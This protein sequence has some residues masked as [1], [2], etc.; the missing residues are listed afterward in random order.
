M[1]ERF[2]KIFAANLDKLLIGK[3]LGAE[4]LGYY[5]IAHTLIIIP[6]FTINPLVTKV[7]FPVFSIIQDNMEKMNSYF[8]KAINLLVTLNFPIYFGMMITAPDF[9]PLIFGEKWTASVAVI[10]ILSLEA[11][12]WTIS[13]PVGSVLL[14]KG[15]ADL[16]FKLNV[17]RS[18]CLALSVLTAYALYPSI[19]S[20]AIGIVTSRYLVDPFIHRFMA[21]NYGV[22]YG[23]ILKNILTISAVSLGMVLTVCLVETLGIE[24]DYVDLALKVLLGGMTYALLLALF[25]KESK[26]LL[27]SLRR[28]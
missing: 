27:L 7:S 13:N 20:V 14:A 17:V 8:S 16:S 28:S 5:T 26:D 9:V 22:N 1:G 3:F 2:L 23:R 10:Q 6:L 25:S 19:E 11:L 12:L 18:C 15:R 4:I 24:N 21:K